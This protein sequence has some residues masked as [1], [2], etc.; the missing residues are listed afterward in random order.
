ME[1]GLELVDRGHLV[2]LTEKVEDPLLS[3]C[4][5]PGIPHRERL[6]VYLGPDY[7]TDLT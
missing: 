6:Y 4:A 2:A 7:H 3:L 1:L 5:P